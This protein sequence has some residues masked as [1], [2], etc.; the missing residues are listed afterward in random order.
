MDEAT[1]ESGET[2]YD[3]V[4]DRWTVYVPGRAARPGGRSV[5]RRVRARTRVD[6]DCPLCPGNETMLPAILRQRH[7][8]ATAPWSTR[9]VPNRYPLVVAAADGLA[10]CHEV[11]IET[12]RHDI[13]LVDMDADRQAGVVAT[14]RDRYRELAPR[15][16]SVVIFRNHG[17]RGGASL[18][19]AHSQIVALDRP[20]PMMEGL[21]RRCARHFSRTG[22]ALVHEAVERELANGRRI[23]ARNRAFAGFVPYWAE[24]PFEIW[25]APVRRQS[26]FGALR[27][28]DI[29]DLAEVLGDVLAR[30]ARRAGNPDYNLTIRGA[31]R[32]RRRAMDACWFV[33]IRP[34]I[35][36]PGGFEYASGMAVNPSLPDLD[37]ATLR[38][39]ENQPTIPV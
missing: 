22:R 37:A 35:T 34:R 31:S 9:I 20:T 3:P 28:A 21:E 2:R 11:V 36:E 30:L 6:A 23:I 1:A 17:P 25:I 19:H 27:D 10:G 18:A 5:G 16:A 7:D 29:D 39:T 13:D 14:W 32:G 33:R 12:S 4:H 26:D 8:A 24:I 15:W 38:G